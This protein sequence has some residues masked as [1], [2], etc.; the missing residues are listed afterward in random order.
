LLVFLAS[1]LFAGWAA[2]QDSTRAVLAR[3]RAHYE[4]LEVEQ[5]LPLFRQVISPQWTAPVTPAQRAEAFKYIGATL[6]I[7]GQRDSGVVYFQAALARDPFTDLDARTFT[8]AQTAAFAAARQTMFAVGARPVTPARVSLR[9]DQVHFTIVTTHS[10]DILARLSRVDSS[11]T[12]VILQGGNDG[13]RDVLW[14]G[15]TP[16]G[17]IAAPGRYALDVVATSRLLSIPDSVRVYFDLRVETPPLEDTLRALPP[18]TLLP[19]HKSQSGAWGDLGKG[20]ALGGGVLLLS[21]GLRDDRLSAGTDARPAIVASAAALSGV[22]A[23]L[24][25]RAHSRIDANIAANRLVRT[26]HDSTNA[27]IRARNGERLARP[28]LVIAP[29]GAVAP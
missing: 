4:R 21:R 22:V 11:T 29:A 13:V 15:L 20:L 19:E 1:A 27:A 3:A 16:R 6:V 24:W 10:A 17:A 7:Q 18:A 8:P 26:T 12:F 25:G 14:D 5:A 23:F 9:T 2:A 28:V